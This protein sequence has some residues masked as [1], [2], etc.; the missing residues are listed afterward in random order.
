MTI[1]RPDYERKV[2][3]RTNKRWCFRCRARFI[4]Y[5][6]VLSEK[7]VFSKRGEHISGGWYEPILVLECRNCGGDHTEFGSG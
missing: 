5:K 7:V 1:C 3:G 4:H 2:I 6:V